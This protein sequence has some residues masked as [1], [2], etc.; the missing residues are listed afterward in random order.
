MAYQDYVLYPLNAP[1]SIQGIF[2]PGYRPVHQE[3]ALL[4]NQAHMTVIKGEGGETERNPDMPCLAQRGVWKIKPAIF[5]RIIH[6]HAHSVL[7]MAYQDY[8]LFRLL[9]L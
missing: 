5:L 8:V 9:R 1:Y 6:P 3:A 7:N 4:L 2:H